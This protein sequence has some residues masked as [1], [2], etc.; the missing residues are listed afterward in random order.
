MLIRVLKELPDYLLNRIQGAMGREAHRLWI[1]GVATTEE[2][3]LGIKGIRLAFV[4]HMKV[5]LDTITS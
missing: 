1:E 2:I 3:E 4:C 5:L